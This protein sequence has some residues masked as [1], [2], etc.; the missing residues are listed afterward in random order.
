M[1]VVGDHPVNRLLAV[2]LLQKEGLAPV[3]ASDGREAIELV[4][5]GD[6]EVV[7]MD[8]QMPDIDGLEATR[9]VRALPLDHQPWIVALTA[10]AFERDRLAC[11]SAGMDHFMSKPFRAAELLRLLRRAP[12]RGR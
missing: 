4:A 1:L 11:L 2:R 3:S 8:M 5:Q 9:R 12:R 7:L 10:N 6:F